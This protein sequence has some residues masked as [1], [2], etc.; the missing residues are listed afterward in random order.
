MTDI[1]TKIHD[2]I[3]NDNAATK[4]PESTYNIIIKETYESIQAEYVEFDPEKH[5]QYYTD[6]ML[7]HK[8]ENTRRL[9]LEELGLSSPEQ[10]SHIGVSDPFPLFTAE[11]I[12][13]MKK[14][15]LNKETFL[16]YA[17]YTYNSSGKDV[18]I[19][20]YSEATPFTQAAWTHPKTMELVS[21]MAGIDLEI[22]FDY[23]I[24]HT[25]VSMKEKDQV[26]KELENYKPKSIEED[27]AVGWHFDSYPFVC[28]LMISDTTNMIGGETSLRMGKGNEGKIVAVPGPVSGS[29]CVLQG[30]LVEHIAPNPVGVSERITM[31]TSYRAKNPKKPDTSVLSTVKPELN[32]GS[33]YTDFYKDWVNYRSDLV[34]ENLNL[35]KKEMNEN[36]DKQ[37]IMDELKALESYIGKT[38]KEMSVSKEEWEGIKENY[39]RFI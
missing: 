37:K 15:I 1:L 22:I 30:R 21:L 27:C 13:I 3:L 2:D 28:V 23:E 7:K 39:K 33:R 17:R 14:E 31:V 16:K 24:A 9:T 20:G 10:I 8:F 6:P 18:C 38:Y 26:E 12:Q 32:F 19:R 29:A 11:A 5:L 35:I 4:V 34:I 36:F 25:N